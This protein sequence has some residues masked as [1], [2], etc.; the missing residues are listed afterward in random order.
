MGNPF[1]HIELQSQA[2]NQAIEF[3]GQLLDWQ[4]ADM[5]MPNSDA[6]YTSINVGEGIGGGMMQHP[7]AGAPSTWVP[8]V[9]VDDV[10]AF[11]EKAKN[12]GA[13]IVRE[14]TEV[15]EHGWFSIIKDP[16]GAVLG[17]WQSK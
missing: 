17:F 5:P 9:E 3:Y 2:V 4:L 10:T 15:P 1:V 11:A 8:Y 13:I 16:A 7:V 12:L 14:K 6:K